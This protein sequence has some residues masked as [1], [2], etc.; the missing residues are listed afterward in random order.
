MYKYKQVGKGNDLLSFAFI[1][2]YRLAKSEQTIET[3]LKEGQKP[4]KVFEAVQSEQE[5]LQ[6]AVQEEEDKRDYGE[7]NEQRAAREDGQV[8]A[9]EV[10]SFILRP[11]Q[12]GLVHIDDT[13]RIYMLLLYL[14]LYFSFSSA[15]FL[16][17]YTNQT[18]HKSKRNKL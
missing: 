8:K 11:D 4:G 18:L 3:E 14:S 17:C 15:L 16:L 12:S 2:N 7:H 6:I 5:L 1:S 10:D 9:Q 13:N